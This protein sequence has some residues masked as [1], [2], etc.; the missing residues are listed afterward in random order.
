MI[1]LELNQT[2]RFF[3]ALKKRWILIYTAKICSAVDKPQKHSAIAIPNSTFTP[4]QEKL[5]QAA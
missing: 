2:D 5:L 3:S 1:E 4:S